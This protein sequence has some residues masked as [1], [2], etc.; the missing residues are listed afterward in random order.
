MRGRMMALILMVKLIL[1]LMLVL[2]M[3]LKLVLMLKLMLKLVPL[4]ILRG[5]AVVF[6][7]IN[8]SLFA[9]IYRLNLLHG[10]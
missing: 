10:L 3:V 7:R 4:L 2:V 1:I 9:Y 8:D 6:C 5:F